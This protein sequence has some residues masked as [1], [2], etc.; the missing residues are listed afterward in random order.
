M[1]IVQKE[2][3]RKKIEIQDADGYEI[4]SDKEFQRYIGSKEQPELVVIFPLSSTED[5]PIA[6]G[7]SAGQEN[8]FHEEMASSNALNSGTVHPSEAVTEAVTATD[9]KTVIIL[10][11]SKV[12]FGLEMWVNVHNV[13]F[14]I[15]YLVPV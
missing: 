12:Y 15:C 3:N 6:S 1:L 4:P 10:D 7:S 5:V 9:G 11:K 13:K 2:S 8:E 14:V